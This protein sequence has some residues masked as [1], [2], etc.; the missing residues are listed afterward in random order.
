MYPPSL[1][2]LPARFLAVARAALV[3]F[4]VAPLVAQ[5]AAWKLPQRG[6]AEYRSAPQAKSGTAESLA[7]ANKLDPKDAPPPGFVPH[8]QPSPWLCQGEL[9][10]DQRAVGDEPRDLRDVL[11]AIAFDLRL[12]G[13]AKA[14]YRRL[15]PFG[16][17]VFTGKVEAPAAD[18]KQ[19]LRLDVTTE[20]PEVRPGE[21]KAL[22]QKW[23]RPLCKHKATGTLRL[24][25]TFDAAKGVVADFEGELALVF[26]EQKGKFRKLVVSDHWLLVDVH[27]NQD[28]AFRG[29]VVKGI[30]DGAKWLQRELGDLL[31]PSLKD[32]DDGLRSYGSGRLALALLTLLHAEVPP[33]DPVVAAGFDEL[34]KRVL[35]DTYS[36][37]VALMA[38]AERYTPPGEADLLRSGTLVAPRPRQLSE[39]DRKLAEEWVTKLR[40]N[41]DTRGD[42]AYRMAFN[43][44]AGPRFDNSVNQYGL[45]GLYAASL[46]QIE[47]PVT[48]WR[49]TANYQLEVQCD[50]NN[51]EL[52]PDLVT[53]KEL[54][55]LQQAEP[56]KGKRT[57]GGGLVPVRGFAYHMPDKPPYGSMTAAGVGSLVI[58]RF[59]LLRAGQGKADVMPKIDAGIQSGFAWLGAEFHVRCNPGDVDH[60]DDSYYYYLYGLE[61]T[62]ELAGVALLGGRDW[63]Y[64]GALQILPQQQKNGAFRPEHPRGYLL[65]ST[66]FAVLFLKK[67]ALPPI[68]GG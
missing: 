33:D 68:T 47:I 24:T 23:V 65:E 55:A 12:A 18:G 60:A 27:D 61:R 16:D 26:E 39:A 67:A 6:A 5:Q 28:A 40:Q 36:L 56:G 17:L 63:Y 52:R 64:E 58:S 25:R 48:V 10:A 41:I 43:Y 57:T 51:R 29:A 3:A 14:R 46:C 13:A 37:A 38:L 22:L 62:C 30:R 2:P 42:P 50:D 66:C 53:Y 7:A 54:T 15:V 20:D 49:A 4:A 21:S 11:R 34:C 32:Q 59:G 31:R 44:T 45:L 19:T 8:F 9:A 1:P 35:V